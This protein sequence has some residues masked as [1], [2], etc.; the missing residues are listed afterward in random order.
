MAEIRTL[1]GFERFL[2]PLSATDLQPAAV[3]G[4]LVLINISELRS[5][6]LV[7]TGAEVEVVPLPAVSPDAVGRQ[8]VAFMSA[9]GGGAERRAHRLRAG[10]AARRDCRRCWSGCG[11]TSPGRFSSISV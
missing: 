10:S 8:V 11:T 5:D 3:D 4:P 2:L 6:A 7:L 9:V 1:D